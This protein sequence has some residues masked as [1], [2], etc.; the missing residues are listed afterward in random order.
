MKKIISFLLVA[1]SVMA[2]TFAVGAD[3][4]N[5]T[6]VRENNADPNLFFYNGKYYLTQTGTSRVA[7]FETEHVDELNEL[8]LTKNISYTAFLNGVIYD[9]A[10]VELFGENAEI[11]GTWSPE[12]H[13]F[14]EEQF[15]GNSGWYMFLALR[16]STGDSS[17]VRMVVL[18]SMTD[19]PK[20]PYGHPTE[21]TRNH[22]QPIL[23]KNGN[24]YDE[25]ACG[26]TV[27]TIPEGQYKGT[28]A[29]WVAEVGRGQSGAEGKFYQ[30]IMIAK[31][32]SPWQLSSDPGVVT[33]PTQSWEY[34]GASSTHPRVVEGATPI[35]GKN[36]E[37]FITYSGSGYWSDY[38][39]GQLTW[40]GGNPLK[41]SSWVKLPVANGN[42]IFS[43]VNAKNLRGAGHAS[44]LT[45]T[46]GNGFVCYHAYAY[47]PDTDKK[48]SSRDAYIEPYYIDYSA[49]NGVSYG[50]IRLGLNG[51]G[52]PADT[53]SVV[54]FATNG[55][56]L[57]APDLTAKDGVSITLTMSESG[58]KGYIIYKSEDGKVFDYLATVDSSTYT[59]ADVTIG[60]TYYYRAYAYREEEISEVSET[61]SASAV[62]NTALP[63]ITALVQKGSSVNVTITAKDKYDY[64]NLYHSADG[65]NYSRVRTITNNLSNPGDTY[66]VAID[67]V[68]VG[69]NYFYV[70]PM[71]DGYELPAEKVY[72][73]D[74]IDLTSPSISN[75]ESTCD[76]VK[77]TFD[78]E[79]E[80]D[81]YTVYSVAVRYG[82]SFY[83]ELAT[84]DTPEYTV[85]NLNIGEEYLFAVSGVF[86][87]I[88]SDKSANFA[89]TLGHSTKD[90][91][92][93]DATC[94]TDGY[95]AYTYC[96]YCE[97]VLS[98][99]TV[100]P[101]S[102]HVDTETE[103]VD[104]TCTADGHITVTCKCGE[105]LSTETIPAS[106]HDYKET[107][108]EIPASFTSVG[109]EAVYTCTSCGDS[110]GGGEIPMLEVGLTMLGDANMDGEVTILDVL[111]TL[112]AAIGMAT[113]IN[114]ANA[115]MDGNGSI[116]VFDMLTILKAAIE[117]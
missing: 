78:S 6:M 20:G 83:S 50:V 114:R 98:G 93:L 82:Y 52:I 13:Y 100:I 61:V 96:E 117:A 5:G 14:S 49:Y 53:A 75:F 35:Y 31:M 102:G 51:N 12:I 91:P 29:M 109:K 46:N 37:V 106:G 33:T 3:T 97:E 11:N 42:P 1:V 22:S 79:R 8:S 73:I 63:E 58:A 110:Y 45:D 26:Q 60:N 30:K 77:L 74:V 84:V 70:M 34:A 39:L 62:V 99:K 55:S 67:A 71:V 9:P 27:L 38:G 104:A 88:Q 95:T 54:T 43:A 90:V 72:T 41:T 4:F 59:D 48:A 103:T 10:V 81:S 16:K 19:S 108:P 44:F 85:E 116:D 18:K 15:P 7:V 111:R 56:Y 112:K 113:E 76:S 17:M 21:G 23:D 57:T 25:W 40:N 65:S 107:E 89:V 24:I 28:Y 66:T 87:G 47:D 115:D 92:M 64:V 80:Y 101:A 36:G 32:S 94:T 68:K 69:T 2:L 86:N 105:V